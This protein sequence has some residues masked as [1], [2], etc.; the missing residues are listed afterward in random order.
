[1]YIY[2]ICRSS[3]KGDFTKGYIGITKR[4]PSIRWL[5]HRLQ[6]KNAKLKRA[7]E[8]FDD[9]IEYVIS[10]GTESYCRW[11]E[12]SWRPFHN[13]GWNNCSGGGVSR[14][15]KDLEKWERAKCLT[16][17]KVFDS[18]VNYAR[19]YCSK[20]CINHS[21]KYTEE[22][23]RKMSAAAKARKSNRLGSTLSEEAKENLRRIVT[24]PHCGKSGG[25]SAMLR[26][27][28]DNCRYKSKV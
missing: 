23:K 12:S 14:Q 18:Y 10:K 20:E 28:F 6:G 11:L 3:D 13:M 26:W 24:C 19:K 8:L 22:A 7:Y 27:H 17:G 1:M 5:E 15:S 16:C 2:H 21:E 25:N 9:I 4:K